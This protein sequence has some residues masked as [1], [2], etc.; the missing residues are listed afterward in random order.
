MAF[1]EN[2]LKRYEA[3]GWHTAKVENGDDG[4][5]TVTGAR[6]ELVLT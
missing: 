4:K 2:V 3:Y 5:Q 1:Q 6:Q